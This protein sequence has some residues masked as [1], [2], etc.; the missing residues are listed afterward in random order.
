MSFCEFAIPFPLFLCATKAN[1]STTTAS[2]SPSPPT[3]SLAR[4][5][6]TTGT[7]PGAGT[8]SRTATRCATSPTCS[9]TGR[10]G[11]STRCRTRAAGA[12]TRPSRMAASSIVTTAHQPRRCL[13]GGGRAAGAARKRVR[14]RRRHCRIR[15]I[16]G[17]AG[18]IDH[19]SRVP[20]SFLFRSRLWFSIVWFSTRQLLLP[21]LLDADM[22]M[23]RALLVSTLL[24]FM[25]PRMSRRRL[26]DES[27]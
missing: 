24:S 11:C 2:S 23:G 14:G 5:S 16:S 20:C 27:T 12:A 9:A 8:C 10:A 4:G 19:Y 7:A 6:T 15:W 3:S 13:P 1:A 18:V 22:M 25:P 26:R 17:E 21:L